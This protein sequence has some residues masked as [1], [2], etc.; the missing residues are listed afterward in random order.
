MFDLDVYRYRS[1]GTLRIGLE[2]TLRFVQGCIASPFFRGFMKYPGVEKEIRD[3]LGENIP[4]GCTIHNILKEDEVSIICKAIEKEGDIDRQIVVRSLLRQTVTD[5]ADI[6][7]LS[8]PT[9]SIRRKKAMD[10]IMEALNG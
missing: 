1:E 2:H 9:V 8:I 7:G 5:I 4:Y 6:L 10:R 3:I